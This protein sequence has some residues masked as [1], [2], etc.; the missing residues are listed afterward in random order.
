MNRSASSGDNG[1]TWKRYLTTSIK[2]S[3]PC[4]ALAVWLSKSAHSIK[5]PRPILLRSGVLQ[6]EQNKLR[7]GVRHP[8]P[9][10]QVRKRRQI[11]NR[12]TEVQQPGLQIGKRTRLQ[13]SGCRAT[14]SRPSPSSPPARDTDHVLDIRYGISASDRAL[15]LSERNFI[16]K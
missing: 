8:L 14:R 13:A 10:L 11:F 6:R 16:G 15:V 9:D 3:T 5:K 12:Q 7:Q 1:R 2:A 4:V